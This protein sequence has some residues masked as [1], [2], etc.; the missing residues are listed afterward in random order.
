MGNKSA[1][2]PEG[3]LNKNVL[4][5]FMAITGPENNASHHNQARFSELQINNL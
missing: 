4:K 1:E 5:S 3:I 2:H